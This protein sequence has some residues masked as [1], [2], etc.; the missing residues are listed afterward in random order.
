M[1]I[2]RKKSIGGGMQ[3]ENFLK[4]KKIN[5]YHHHQQKS[6]LVATS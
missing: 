6:K 5:N 1:S 3:S 2:L 4:V